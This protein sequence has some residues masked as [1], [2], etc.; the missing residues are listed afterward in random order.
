[1]LLL[2]CDNKCI[3]IDDSILKCSDYFKN[4]ITTD[5]EYYNIRVD[6]TYSDWQSFQ[7]ITKELVIGSMDNPAYCEYLYMCHKYKFIEYAKDVVNKIHFINTYITHPHLIKFI[8]NCDPVSFPHIKILYINIFYSIRDEK[9]DLIQFTKEFPNFLIDKFIPFINEHLVIT[10]PTKKY[11]IADILLDNIIDA[12]KA[13][14]NKLNEIKIEDITK[15]VETSIK[16][17]LQYLS[18]L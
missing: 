7:R 17:K 10:E 15:L 1:M 16:I 13:I 5:Q 2:T 12:K 9:I 18:C 14:I 4:A 3:N 8:V 6:E 11:S